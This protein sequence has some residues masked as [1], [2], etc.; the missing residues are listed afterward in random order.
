MPCNQPARSRMCDVTVCNSTGRARPGDHAQPAV[1]CERHQTRPSSRSLH[2]RGRCSPH[3]PRRG[4]TH[5]VRIGTRSISRP[6]PVDFTNRRQT[7][8]ASHSPTSFDHS[9]RVPRQSNDPK[10]ITPNGAPR[11][12]ACRA[13]A[14]TRHWSRCPLAAETAPEHESHLASPQGRCELSTP[15]SNLMPRMTPDQTPTMWFRGVENH[16]DCGRASSKCVSS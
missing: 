3:E 6:K 7:P 15:T 1:F 8:A 16:R 13:T 11:D 14:H 9:A 2:R 4:R 12:P 10:T 5:A